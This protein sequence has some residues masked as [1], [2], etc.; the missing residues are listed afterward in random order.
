MNQ[1]GIVKRTPFLAA[2]VLAF[3]ACARETRTPIVVYSPH[4]RDLLG[5]VEKAYEAKHPDI[6]IRWLDMGSQEVYDRIRAEKANP[7]CDLWYGG[8]NT[9]FA[10][11]V[12]DGLLEAFEPGWASAVPAE[13]RHGGLYTGL[14]RTPVAILYNSD[15]V[16]REDAP[17]EWDDLLAPRFK[18]QVLVR[19]PIASGTMRAVWGMVLSRSVAETGNPDRGF[20][21]LARLDGQTK[22]Y[23]VN[24]S[25]LCEKIARREGL[26]T[27]WDLPDILLEKQRSPVLAFVFPKSGAPVIDDGVGLVKGAKH[28]AQA[29]ALM[30][31]LGSPE[32]QLAAA[33]KAFRLPAR[34]DLPK[35]SLP[36]WAREVAGS[37]V[38]ARLDWDLI[39]REGPGWMARWDR[40][41]KG[42]SAR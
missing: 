11:G 2:A 33:D 25:I 26:V 24:A 1:R 5:L 19:D 28:A 3:A 17:R 21:W 18:G 14:Y 37:L 16:S 41:I 12:R 30:E 13:S 7:Q 27:I 4:G 23:V 35:E 34:T 39:E 32:A 42:R 22:E 38:P 36:A 8:P 9:I 31:W 29:R 10:R 20:A 15:A 6:D 40:E